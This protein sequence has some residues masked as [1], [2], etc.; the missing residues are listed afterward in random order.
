LALIGYVAERPVVTEN[1]R[2]KHWL[3]S[4]DKN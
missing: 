4:T 2:R 3:V 1:L